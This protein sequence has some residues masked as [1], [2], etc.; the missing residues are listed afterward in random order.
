A[1]EAAAE[2]AWAVQ[3]LEGEPR[4]FRLWDVAGWAA[5]AEEGAVDKWLHFQADILRCVVGN[6]FRSLPILDRSLLEKAPIPQLARTAYEERSLPGGTLDPAR[7]AVL[8]DTLEEAGCR[9]PA[10]L[11]HCRELGT[12]HVRGCWVLDLI[13]RNE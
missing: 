10:V 3:G 6:P 8:A 2:A 4:W 5:T 12:N 1:A 9:D 11:N 7:L 13:L